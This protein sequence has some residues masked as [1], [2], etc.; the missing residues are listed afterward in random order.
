MEETRNPSGKKGDRIEKAAELFQQAY[1]AQLQGE[2]G[3]AV[4]L[5]QESIRTHPTAEAHTFLGW[6]YSFLDR[7]E[8]AIAECK[9]AIAVD[10]D[11]GNPYNDIGSYLI[12]LGKLD[13]AIPWLERALSAKRY[14]PRHYPHMNLGR[15][16][17]AKGDQLSAAREFGRALEIEPRYRPARFAL[18]ALSAQ[19]N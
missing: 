12:K 15:L 18:A 11:F 2:L 19:L 14:E 6:A 5:Y 7:Y 3:S 1:R 16:Y 17:L 10:P 4:R 9:N 13:D 8:D